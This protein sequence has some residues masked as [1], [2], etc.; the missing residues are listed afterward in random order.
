MTMANK[1]TCKTDGCSKD[2]QAKGYCPRHY[3]QWRKGKLAKPRYKTCNT[4]NCR[5]R[6]ERRGLCAEHFAKEYHKSSGEG[7]AAATPAAGA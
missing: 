6:M 3:R 1:G 4:E 2:V 5:K 7:A